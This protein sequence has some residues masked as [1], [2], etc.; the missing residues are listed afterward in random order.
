M[1]YNMQMVDFQCRHVTWQFQTKILFPAVKWR[2]ILGYEAEE[3]AHSYRLNVKKRLVVFSL[4]IREVLQLH[5]Q[6]H[7]LTISNHGL[8]AIKKK[9]SVFWINGSVLEAMSIVT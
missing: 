3:D 7:N 2:L 4:A 9:K 6:F 8:N 5:S 1:D